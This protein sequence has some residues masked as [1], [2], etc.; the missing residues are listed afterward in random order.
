MSIII[1]HLSINIHKS[2]IASFPQPNLKKNS[3]RP[4]R[5]EATSL[6]RLSNTRGE[7]HS[8]FSF[9]GNYRHPIRHAK[10]RR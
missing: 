1:E 2:N 4:T 7:I 6:P 3:S 5:V 10:S 9:A 8:I